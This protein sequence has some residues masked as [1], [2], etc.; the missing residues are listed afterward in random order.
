MDVERQ[1]YDLMSAA[2]DH[3]KA[4]EAALQG[5][6]EEQAALSQAA[7]HMSGV[8]VA[9]KRAAAEAVPVIQEAVGASVAKSLVGASDEAAKALSEAT[10][11]ILDSLSNVVRAADGVENKLLRATASFGWKW[12]AL[13]GGAAAGGIVAVVL[14]GWLSIWWQRHEVQSLLDQKAALQGEV[15][16]LQANVAT[17]EKKGGRIKLDKCGPE[18]RLCIEIT[19]NQGKDKNQV[20]FH[21]SWTDQSEKRRFVIPMG[22]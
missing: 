8:V 14:I 4:V 17:L 12:I 20:D 3:K 5:L 15:V 11:P 10:K 16:E 6:T 19:P 1:L 2:E 18:S 13:A 22:Y 9:V 7:A 21:G